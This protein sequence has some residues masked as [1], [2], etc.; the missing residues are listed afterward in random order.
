MTRAKRQLVVIGDTRTLLRKG[1]K[2]SASSP[3]NRKFL[4]KW[5]EWLG[6]NSEKQLSQEYVIL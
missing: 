3:F 6:K 5:I 4:I 1:R 2:T